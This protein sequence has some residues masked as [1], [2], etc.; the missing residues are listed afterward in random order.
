[1]QLGHTYVID[2]P[3]PSCNY[4]D[5]CVHEHKAAAYMIEVTAD[6]RGY[7]VQQKYWRLRPYLSILSMHAEATLSLYL[8][9]SLCLQLTQCLD[10]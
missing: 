10:L 1:M 7:Y 2:K 8:T 5:S 6:G 3:L 4:E 9:D